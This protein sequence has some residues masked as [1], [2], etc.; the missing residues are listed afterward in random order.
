MDYSGDLARLKALLVDGLITQEDYDEQK[1][2]LLN[3]RYTEPSGGSVYGQD[4]QQSYNYAAPTAK[5]KGKGCLIAAVI[6]AIVIIL[7]IA[8]PSLGGGVIT[9]SDSGTK[10]SQTAEEYKAQCKDISY[11]DLARKP[12]SY[13]GQYIKFTGEIIQV[14]ESGKESQYRINVTK[15]EYDLWDDTVFV[16]YQNKDGNE[17]FLE[18]DIV[19]FYGKYQGLL[20]YESILGQEISVPSCSAGYIDLIK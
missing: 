13:K 9:P 17:R 14:L 16:T 10:Q 3:A 18:D 8:V 19:T 5:K 6:I 4:Q 1:K 11:S 15:G 2:R 20:K 12:D 7:I